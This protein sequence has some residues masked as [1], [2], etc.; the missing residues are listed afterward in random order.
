MVAIM[1]GLKNMFSRH[2]IKRKDSKAQVESSILPKPIDFIFRL[3]L[4]MEIALISWGLNPPF[5]L[6]VF[7]IARGLPFKI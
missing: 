2:K 5:G 4:K 3:I 6:S 1:R 7:V